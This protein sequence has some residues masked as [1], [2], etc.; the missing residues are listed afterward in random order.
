MSSSDSLEERK[1]R[2]VK[3]VGGTATKHSTY[4]C[5][6]LDTGKVATTHYYY[7]IVEKPDPED[8]EMTYLDSHRALKINCLNPDP[9]P[10]TYIEAAFQ[11]VPQ[12]GQR[13][14]SFAKMVAKCRIQRCRELSDKIKEYLDRETLNLMKR[15]SS[16]EY[17]IIDTTELPDIVPPED[18]SSGRDI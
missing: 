4:L 11:Q 10:Q 2:P 15:G 8:P 1:G 5:A 12:L 7:I 14:A 6:W 3:L 18:D 17:R 9:E 13:L 16:A